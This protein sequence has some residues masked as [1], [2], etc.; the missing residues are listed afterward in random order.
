MKTL[1]SN[2]QQT[3]AAFE[4]EAG[5]APLM[6]FLKEEETIGAKSLKDIAK[7]WRKNN[8]RGQVVEGGQKR[9]RKSRT[10]EVDGFTVLK[11]NNY[12]MEQGEPSVYASEAK[13]SALV[14]GRNAP[15]SKRDRGR[16]RAGV[17]FAHSSVC[18]SCWDGGDLLCCD[19][20]PVALHA[21]CAGYTPAEVRAMR[22]Y[23]CSHHQCSV[24][25]RKAQAVGGM[26]F[27]C[28]CCPRAFCEDH[29]PQEAEIVGRCARFENLNQNRPT[30]AC[31][32]RCDKDCIAWANSPNFQQV[33]MRP[34]SDPL[35]S[36]SLTPSCPPPDLLPTPSLNP[37]LTPSWG[38]ESERSLCGRAPP[39]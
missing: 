39:L 18:Q 24:C 19:L 33:G 10:I 37:S 22:R 23:A 1:D 27:R 14:A 32:I 12:D 9:E 20:C 36:P 29:R 11:E 30:S 7:E 21:E 8:D 3:A 5:S 35:L 34:L 31:F 26:L 13:P 6:S 25:G 38:Q 28:E 2:S 17:D 16:Q 15:S 4:A